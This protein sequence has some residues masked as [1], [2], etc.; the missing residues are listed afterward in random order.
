MI[1]VSYSIGNIELGTYTLLD[2]DVRGTAK[3][4]GLIHYTNVLVKAVM[5]PSINSIAA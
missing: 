1:K 5:N 3:A 4:H 2:G